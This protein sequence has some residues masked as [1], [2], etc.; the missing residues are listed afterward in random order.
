MRAGLHLLPRSFF[1]CFGRF[2][3][4]LAIQLYSVV[5][6]ARLIY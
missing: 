2:G 1:P 3:R 4:R 6:L 5:L